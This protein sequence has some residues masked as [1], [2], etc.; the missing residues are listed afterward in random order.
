MTDHLKSDSEAADAAGECPDPRMPLPVP[1]E[2]EAIHE[3]IVKLLQALVDAE[4]D[5]C[6]G[7]SFRET[8]CH[9]MELFGDYLRAVVTGSGY[10]P[11]CRAGCS[12]C[13]CHWADDVYSFEA[14]IIA[15]AVRARGPAVV[16]AVVRA[17]RRSLEEYRRVHAAAMERLTAGEY[18]E[19]GADL[20][21]DEVVLNSFYQLKSRCPLLDDDDRCM[22]YELR[23]L[24]CRAYVNLGDPSLCPPEMIHE[25]DALTW[26]LDLDDDGNVLLDRLNARH[27]RYP[28][29]GGLRSLL[30][31][32]LEAI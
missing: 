12:I 9:A 4:D 25:P 6:T 32:Y 1:P 18:E 3:E 11:A 13:C 30:L 22:V 31:K 20:D 24:T 26:V 7:E 14:A 15:Q 19:L 8:Y 2:A 21:P 17:C 28:G 5:D 10:Q 29:D 27:E 16:D 23:P